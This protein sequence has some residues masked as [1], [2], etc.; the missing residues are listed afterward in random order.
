MS[1]R[2]CIRKRIASAR[3]DAEVQVLQ[4]RTRTRRA[5]RAAGPPPSDAAGDPQPA[6]PPTAITAY[7]SGP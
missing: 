5:Q 1:A 3:G 7:R 6:R 2:S 4:A